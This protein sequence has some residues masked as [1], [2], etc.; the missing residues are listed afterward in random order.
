MKQGERSKLRSHSQLY[1]HRR[2]PRDVKMSSNVPKSISR[3]FVLSGCMWASDEHSSQL[4]FNFLDIVFS[5]SLYLCSEHNKRHKALNMNYAVTRIIRVLIRIRYATT[6]EHNR[7]RHS[8]R[9]SRFASAT[10][11]NYFRH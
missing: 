7:S 10:V 11:E 1:T 8:T 5:F 4:L 6:P 2:A 9:C 3:L